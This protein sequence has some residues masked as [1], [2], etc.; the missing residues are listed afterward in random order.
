M[1]DLRSFNCR[2]HSDLSGEVGLVNSSLLSS[3]IRG[4]IS[5]TTL[6][7]IVSYAHVPGILLLIGGGKVDGKR[8]TIRG[9][10]LSIVEELSPSFTIRKNARSP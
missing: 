8:P 6:L 7:D 9:V 5:L 2:K 10:P 1:L 3:I 4:R